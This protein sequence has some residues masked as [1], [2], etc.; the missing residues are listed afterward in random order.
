M[1][2]VWKRGN[3]DSRASVGE[4]TVYW[5]GKTEEGAG[6]ANV[7]VDPNQRCN[8]LLQKEIF[9]SLLC[10][11][12]REMAELPSKATAASM[13]ITQRSGRIPYSTWLLKE[14]TCGL[15]YHCIA[16]CFYNFTYIMLC[17]LILWTLRN[18]KLS[19]SPIV[20]KGKYILPHI[21]I[22]LLCNWSHLNHITTHCGQL[23]VLPQ[24]YRSEHWASGHGF[25]V[26]Y[27]VSIKIRMSFIF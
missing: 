23:Q 10:R 20:H 26:I 2:S 7:V 3:H 13:V 19:I 16:Q 11:P 17:T 14:N 5:G 25:D 9:I 22:I 24:L 8:S 21:L 27:K 15:W 12:A 4:V 18:R 6:L 1:Q